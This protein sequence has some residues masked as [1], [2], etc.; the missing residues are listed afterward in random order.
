MSRYV[1][2]RLKRELEITSVE[3]Q[4][5]VQNPEDW[6]LTVEWH[7]AERFPLTR[8]NVVRNAP[9]QSGVY[10]LGSPG[11]WIYIAQ[12]SNMQRDLLRFLSGERPYVLEW[13]PSYFVV[14]EVPYSRRN[15]RYKELSQHY[16]PVCNRK[17]ERTG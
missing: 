3:Y 11:K 6:L 9:E 8:T 2:C 7:S 17:L 12:T 4:G 5:V 15:A 10:G 13:D 16:Q 14:E 1:V